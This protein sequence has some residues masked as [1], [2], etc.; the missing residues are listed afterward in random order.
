MITDK[1][2]RE[3]EQN[4][5]RYFEEELLKKDSSHAQF[6]KF[7]VNN[8][9]MSFQLANFLLKLSTDKEIKKNAGFPEDFECL[10]WVVVTS[11][12]S[13]FY[14]ANAA[15]ARLGLKVGEKIAHK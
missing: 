7:Y 4:L 12:Y 11:Y 10:L 1:E 15:M 5:R 8:A 6:V 14:I 9:K 3:A 2:I 13:M